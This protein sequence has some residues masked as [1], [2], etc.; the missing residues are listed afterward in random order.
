LPAGIATVQDINDG[1][2]RVK[3]RVE[4]LD[5]VPAVLAGLDLPFA[6]EQPDELRGLVLSLADRLTAAATQQRPGSST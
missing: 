3:L 5:W 6:V 4:R 2:V 1:W